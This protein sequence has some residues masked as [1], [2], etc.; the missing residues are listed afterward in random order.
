MGSCSQFSTDSA[1]K[2]PTE[3][4]ERSPTETEAEGFLYTYIGIV[5]NV[6]QSEMV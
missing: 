1:T 4:A 2:W 6:K 5:K 3:I